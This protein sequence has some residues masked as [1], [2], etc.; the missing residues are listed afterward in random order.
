MN[1]CHVTLHPICQNLIDA[2]SVGGL[3]LA[4]TRQSELAPEFREL[5]PTGSFPWW[6]IAAVL[7]LL[8]VAFAA[9]WTIAQLRVPAIP[10]SDDLTL[11]LCR[12]HRI[13]LQQRVVLDHVARM[14]K[15]GRTA[16]LFLSPATFDQAIDRA[17][18]AKRLRGGQRES[19]L[20][21]RR[22]IFSNSP[23]A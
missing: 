8:V 10:I 14:A 19:L 13:G 7:L 23:Q 6:V 20:M 18:R 3:L 15:L 22:L 5:A 21:V 4:E 2:L 17:N 9:Y 11:E 16:E 1:M 12:A